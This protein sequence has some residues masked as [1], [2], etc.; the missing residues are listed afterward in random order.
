[1]PEDVAARLAGEEPDYHVKDLFD[2]IEAGDYPSWTV[3]V[4]VM[5]PEEAP[6]A[7]IDIFDNTFTWPHHLYPLR[8]IGRLTL[9]KNVRFYSPLTYE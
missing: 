9:N 5:Q 8:P 4:Q 2:S 7:P 1:M 6:N 3:S